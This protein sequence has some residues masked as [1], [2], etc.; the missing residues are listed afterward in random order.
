LGRF[1]EK[2][3]VK[4]RIAEG[5][6]G[7][8]VD[9]WIGPMAVYFAK[10][11]PHG[12]LERQSDVGLIR[13][14]AVFVMRSEARSAEI[15]T[16][17]KEGRTRGA[18]V[19]RDVHQYVRLLTLHE[20]VEDVVAQNGVELPVRVFGEVMWIIA[21][22]F[23]P[24]CSEEFYVGTMATAIV[25]HATLDVAEAEEFP[26]WEGGTVAILG[27]EMGIGIFAIGHDE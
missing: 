16:D 14:H 20:H 25:Q 12:R 26:G 6:F 7:V 9:P 23:E 17:C 19:F 2:G 24:F 8:V 3:G 15:T 13:R 5:A 22:H 1:G 10:L 4:G 21:F 11:G 27:C 18:K